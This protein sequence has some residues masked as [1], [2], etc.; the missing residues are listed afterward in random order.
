MCLLVLLSIG[1]DTGGSGWVSAIIACVYGIDFSGIACLYGIDF[2]GNLFRT[3]W[4]GI[5]VIG[6]TFTG[7]SFGFG[8]TVCSCKRFLPAR[9][10][11]VLGFLELEQNC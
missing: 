5:S 4:I 2:F 10:G 8:T 9:L 1:I 7:V 11:G 3:A 6:T